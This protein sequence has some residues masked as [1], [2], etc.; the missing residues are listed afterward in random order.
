[1]TK[2]SDTQSTI[3]T[4]APQ[5]VDGNLLPLSSSLRGDAAVKVVGTLL[6]RD[7]VREEMT[8]RTTRADSALNTAWRNE[9]DGRAVMP[10]TTRMGSPRLAWRWMPAGRCRRRSLAR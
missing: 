8:E 10:R 5:R 6:A 9:D 7:L 1:M 4:A 2:L 3:L